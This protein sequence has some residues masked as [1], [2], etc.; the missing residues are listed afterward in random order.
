[1]AP[2]NANSERERDSLQ[3]RYTKRKDFGRIL[4]TLL[5]EEETERS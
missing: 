3:R 5:A 2:N 1:M 4:R